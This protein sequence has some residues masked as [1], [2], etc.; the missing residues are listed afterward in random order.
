[1][2]DLAEK[3]CWGPIDIA[4]AVLFL[5]SDESRVTTGSIFVT[6]SGATVS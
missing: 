1:M 2:P 4:R 3:I 5:V 6:E